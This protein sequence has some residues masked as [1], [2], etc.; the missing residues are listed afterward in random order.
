MLEPI[1]S[2]MPKL[3]INIEDLGPEQIVKMPRFGTTHYFPNAD[4]RTA[5]AV[6]AFEEFTDGDTMSYVTSRNVAC[7]VIKGK[8]K[9]TYSLKVKRY[10]EE[11]ELT[12]GPGDVYI[13]PKNTFVEWK[14][15]PGSRFR[16]LYVM[17]N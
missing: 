8:A 1:T 15:I 3:N 13:I 5:N 7:I 11:K 2:E 16:H 6:L 12:V 9:I 14:V 10:T 17:T 4:I